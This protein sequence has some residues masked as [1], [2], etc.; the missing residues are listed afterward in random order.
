MKEKIIVDKLTNSEGE[1]I[2]RFYK[3]PFAISNTLGVLRLN[4]AIKPILRINHEPR[5]A[6]TH[7]YVLRAT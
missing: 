4:Y 5:I 3:C 6:S 1:E 7:C 2:F